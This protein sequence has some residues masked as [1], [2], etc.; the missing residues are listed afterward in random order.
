MH[1]Y[2]PARA[3]RP[4]HLVILCFIILTILDW[5]HKLS[6]FSLCYFLRSSP[7]SQ[8]QQ[9]FSRSLNMCWSVRT[10]NC[11]EVVKLQN[12]T[13]KMK[14]NQFQ[15]RLEFLYNKFL[16]NFYTINLITSKTFIS[17]K[18]LTAKYFQIKSVRRPLRPCGLTCTS[19][20]PRMPTLRVRIPLRTWM[21]VCWV[22]CVL[23]R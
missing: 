4:S 10:T 3:T 7:S 18:F 9:F 15:N 20:A 1:P 17:F 21:L 12:P 11:A 6:D 16:Y 8:L 19:A 22:R 2:L 5:D 14:L 23:C 13:T